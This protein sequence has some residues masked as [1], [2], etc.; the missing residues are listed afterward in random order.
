MGDENY[1][2]ELAHGKLALI[3]GQEK[4]ARLVR[5]AVAEG[6]LVEISSAQDLLIFSGV[7]KMRGGFEATVGAMLGLQAVLRGAVAT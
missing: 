5:E 4:A 2:N 3:F 7:L 1:F 6:G